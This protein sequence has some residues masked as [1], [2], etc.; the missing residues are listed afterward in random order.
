ME[1]NTEILIFESRTVVVYLMSF[2]KRLIIC[3]LTALLSVSVFAP[4][5]SAQG[6][7]QVKG[8]V[9]DENGEPFPGVAVISRK[10]GLGITTDIDGKFVLN[11]VPVKAVLTVEIVSYKSQEIRVLM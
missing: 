7:R 2:L 9:Y 10:L 1:L 8:V 5:L 4:P 11:G 3:L 6:T